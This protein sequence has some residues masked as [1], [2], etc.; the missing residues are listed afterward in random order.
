MNNQ[1]TIFALVVVYIVLVAVTAIVGGWALVQT[2]APTMALPI[3]ILGLLAWF[4]I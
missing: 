2:V 3:A 1:A 4:D